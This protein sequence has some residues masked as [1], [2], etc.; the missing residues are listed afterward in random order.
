M[1]ASIPRSCASMHAAFITSGNR[2]S[3]QRPLPLLLSWMSL[4]VLQEGTLFSSSLLSS[5][6]CKPYVE[7]PL[8]LYA[9][10]GSLMSQLWRDN[11]AKFRRDTRCGR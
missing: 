11:P 9:F 8:S 4:L 5:T 7:R 6:L 2:A 1:P 3:L 10:G